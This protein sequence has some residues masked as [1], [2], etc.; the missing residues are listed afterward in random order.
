MT[1]TN[2]FTSKLD[3]DTARKVALAKVYRILIRLA[4]ESEQ[5]TPDG[6]DQNEEKSSKRSSSE[7]VASS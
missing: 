5:D 3:P 6:V 4:E 7:E 2:F 1:Q